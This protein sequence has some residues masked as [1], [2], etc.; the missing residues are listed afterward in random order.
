[1]SERNTTQ[2]PLKQLLPIIEEQ[3]SAGGLV[4]FSPR[5]IS[6][7]PLIREGKDSVTLCRPPKRLKKYDLPL[8]RRDSGQFVLHR[9]VAVK[10]DGTYTMCGDNQWVLEHG[11]RQD[12]IIAVVSSLHRDGKDISIDTPEYMRYSRRRVRQQYWKGLYYRL[13]ARAA[14]I[15]KKRLKNTSA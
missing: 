12:Q 15:I 7:L 13:R 9:V 3:M 4:T 5:G 1:M 14:G 10:K 2:V 8:Y 11:I 6:M